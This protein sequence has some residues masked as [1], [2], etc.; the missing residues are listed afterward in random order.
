ME[1]SD[2][3]GFYEEFKSAYNKLLLACKE[4]NYEKAYYAGFMID[5]ETQLFLIH[6]TNQGVFPNIINEVLTNNFESIRAK[7]IEH[8]RQLIKLLNENNIEINDFKD[9]AEFREHFV[10]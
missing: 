2:L 1:Y 3:A 8:E 10:D 6:Y 7:C 9:F 5:R 4:E